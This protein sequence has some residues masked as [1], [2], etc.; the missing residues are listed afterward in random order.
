M[1]GAHW[2]VLGGAGD[3]GL[4]YHDEARSDGDCDAR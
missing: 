2:C 1:G 3:G 4:C